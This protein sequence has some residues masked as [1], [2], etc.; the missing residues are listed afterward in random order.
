MFRVIEKPQAGDL[1]RVKRKKGYC[2]YG[3]ATSEDTVVHFTGAEN[4]LS[5]DGGG[6][7]VRE[8]SLSIFVKQDVLTVKS[9][10]DSP[11]TREE[12]VER[13]R[14]FI[15]QTRF[16]KKKYNFITNNCEHFARYI[17]NGKAESTQ[18]QRGTKVVKKAGAI[19][20]GVATAVGGAVAT[21][22]VATKKK[23]KRK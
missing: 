3:I 10:E 4:D 14:S 6:I 16:R 13:A 9:A 11:F 18:V 8:T 23:L 1:L 12:I 19:A 5:Y 7:M 15:G 2:H 17:F 21:A 22:V 20:V